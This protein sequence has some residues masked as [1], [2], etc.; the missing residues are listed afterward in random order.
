ML[1]KAIAAEFDK[2]KRFDAEIGNIVN[3]QAFRPDATDLELT[4]NAVLFVSEDTQVSPEEIDGRHVMISKNCLEL[5]REIRAS[6]SQLAATD[7]LRIQLKKFLETI[8]QMSQRIMTENTNHFKTDSSSSTLRRRFSEERLRKDD[9]PE[10]IKAYEG[11]IKNLERLLHENYVAAHNTS[12][13]STEFRIPY[14]AENL[15]RSNSTSQAEAKEWKQAVD[16]IYCKIGLGTTP[17]SIAEAA[18]LIIS[19]YSEK[20]ALVEKLQQR[21]AFGCFEVENI[22]LLLPTVR[23][24]IWSLFNVDYPNYYVHPDS[25][26]IMLDDREKHSWF[27]ARIQKIEPKKSLGKALDPYRL[28][29]DFEYHEVVASKLF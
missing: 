11:R 22:V 29:K 12:T 5:E 7:P 25:L 13:E 10:L 9:N 3:L 28:P 19:G 14:E 16:Q 18:R 21:I 15:T 4:G 23:K 8:I 24:S 20:S 1:E 26:K 6:E 27:L 2:R 17:P